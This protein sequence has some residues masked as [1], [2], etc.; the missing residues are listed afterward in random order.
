[1]TAHFPE[2]AAAADW[3]RQVTRLACAARSESIGGAA[4]PA[5]EELF[6]LLHTTGIDMHQRVLACQDLDLLSLALASLSDL[7]S[8]N[9]QCAQL[10]ALLR[11]HIGSLRNREREYPVQLFTLDCVI[12]P[13]KSPIGFSR[14]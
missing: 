13:T 10:L 14:M 7:A 5:A 2:A 6:S 4:S 12:Q 9:E 8:P 11:A 3:L 1:M